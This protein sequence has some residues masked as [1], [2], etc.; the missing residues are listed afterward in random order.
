M[1]LRRETPGGARPGTPFEG[2]VAEIVDGK[3][4]IDYEDPY[5]SEGTRLRE[6]D[7]DVSSMSGVSVKLDCQSSPSPSGG[8]VIS[9]SAD[10]EGDEFE[11]KKIQYDVLVVFDSLRKEV[12]ASVGLV[13]PGSR[14]DKVAVPSELWPSSDLPLVPFVW[15]QHDDGGATLDMEEELLPITIEAL[16]SQQMAEEAV[17]ALMG[18]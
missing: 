12:R 5:G 17:Q 14:T 11:T 4:V 9:L 7:V 8:E 10:A 6:V 18:A 3:Y 16:T 1:K 13:G 2:K 15:L